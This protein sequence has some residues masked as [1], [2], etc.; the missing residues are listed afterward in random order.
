MYSLVRRERLNRITFPVSTVSDP[1]D[2][3]AQLKARPELPAGYCSM[4]SESKGDKRDS[5]KRNI[6]NVHLER[7]Q[8]RKNGEVRRREGETIRGELMHL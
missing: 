6:K 7:G 5:P 4:I 8:R 1:R 2:F 3:G